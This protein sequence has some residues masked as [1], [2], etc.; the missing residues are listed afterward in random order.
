MICT[1]SAIELTPY[2]VNFCKLVD[3]N[4]SIVTTWFNMK[5]EIHY[6]G[7]W[8]RAV[9]D[10]LDSLLLDVASCLVL[11]MVLGGVYWAKVAISPLET[12][13]PSFFET[14]DPFFIQ[15]LVIGIRG[16]LSVVY[17]TWTTY[18]YGTTAGKRALKIYVVSASS[19][20]PLTLRQS[21]I[22][23]LSYL[24]SYLPLGTGFLM[25]AFHP[26]KRALHD[27]IAGTVSLVKTAE[28]G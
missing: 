1:R 15:I 7:F 19:F 3:K 22:R 23:C 14:V 21:L 16:V 27:L 17:F 4:G 26:Q 28:N 5:K 24:V 11:L 6:A 8:V 18:V 25:V 20:S 9:A 2:I 13:R 12:S 10:L